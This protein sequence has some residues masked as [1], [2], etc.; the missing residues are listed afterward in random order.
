MENDEATESAP[1]CINRSLLEG[2]DD[3]EEVEEEVDEEEGATDED[4]SIMRV[5][6]NGSMS[7][8][9]APSTST[10]PLRA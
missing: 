9:S 8:E 6:V 3:N 2:S 4:P 7:D 10:S 1:V 5:F